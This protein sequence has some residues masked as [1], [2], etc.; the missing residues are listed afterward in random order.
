MIK[1]SSAS[2]PRRAWGGA[3]GFSNECLIKAAE[4]QL[5]KLPFYH[6]FSHK[7]H[8]PSI[9]LAE[10]LIEM[11]P[12]PMSK[13]FF[14][15]SGSDAN[16]TVV[17]LIWCRIN[18]IGKPRF[19]ECS[20]PSVV[21]SMIPI[22]GLLWATTRAVGTSG[23]GTSTSHCDSSPKAQTARRQRE[24]VGQVGAGWSKPYRCPTHRG[25]MEQ[26]IRQL[27]VRMQ[28][29]TRETV[30]WV[31]PAERSTSCAARSPASPAC[32]AAMI[33]AGR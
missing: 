15:N 4:Q 27:S 20:K 6:L 22:A 9:E 32:L 23:K 12:V 5:R 29:I 16:D 26:D 17:K 7:A 1:A 21:R 2:R 18:A 3:L 25:N 14:T 31:V 24:S 33:A 28:A 30:P 19:G 11:A 13:V 10:Q 8:S